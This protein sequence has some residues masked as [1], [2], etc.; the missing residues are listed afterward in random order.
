MMRNEAEVKAA[1]LDRVRTGA[2]LDH[3]E[4]DAERLMKALDL[5]DGW[6]TRPLPSPDT[7][8]SGHR[9]AP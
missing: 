3:V 7:S 8:G 2:H 6:V 4:R 1:L 5:V 9:E